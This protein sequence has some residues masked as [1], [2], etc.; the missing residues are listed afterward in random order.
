M[1]RSSLHRKVPFCNGWRLTLIFTSQMQLL[2]LLFL[3][4]IGCQPDTVNQRLTTS[5]PQP[6]R[7]ALILGVDRCV[8]FSP[9]GRWLAGQ[10][11]DTSLG[12]GVVDTRSGEG[13][14]Y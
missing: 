1:F 8:A 3:P 10:L 6:R 2:P 11:S 12:G 4:V 9:D 14:W 13:V 7:E 5:F